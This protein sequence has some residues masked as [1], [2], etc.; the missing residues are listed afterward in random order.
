MLKVSELT[1]AYSR[2][3]VLSKLSFQGK[4]GEIMGVLGKNG[5]GKSTLLQAL[6]GLKK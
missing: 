3:E 4:R 2:K 1:L 5:V 6:V